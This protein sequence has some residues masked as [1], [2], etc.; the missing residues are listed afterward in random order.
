MIY[1]S[2]DAGRPITFTN[3][4]DGDKPVIRN[5]ECSSNWSSVIDIRADWVVINDLKIQDTHDD[6]IYISEGSDHNV[7]RNNDISTVGIGVGIHG[8][9][10][11]NH[12]EYNP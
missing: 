1:S 2:G 5:P 10:N 6:G 8:Q 12:T 3:Y 7:I 4:G 9:Y 11:F